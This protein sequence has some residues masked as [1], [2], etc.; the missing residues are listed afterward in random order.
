[1]TVEIKEYKTRK[2]MKIGKTARNALGWRSLHTD[3]I[4]N[5]ERDGYRV[6][7]VNGLDN[8]E[9]SEDG[10]IRQLQFH[11]TELLNQRIE[12]DTLTFGELKMLLRLER[13]M[14]L[15]PNTV[16]KIRSLLAGSPIGIIQR[17]KNLFNV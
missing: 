16:A 1:M 15:T 6:T 9:N 12:T 17:I 10:K 13:G 4:N 14:E 2:S 8:E 3:F 5:I 11:L 7:Y